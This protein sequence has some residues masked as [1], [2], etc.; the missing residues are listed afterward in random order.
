L[1]HF[2][3]HCA[4]RHLHLSFPV[5]VESCG[6]TSVKF[7][8]QTTVL[9]AASN[10][11]IKIW[12]MR[13]GRAK[14]QFIDPTKEGFITS[15]TR[16]PLQFYHFTTGYSNGTIAL[17]DTRQNAPFMHLQKHSSH[18]WEVHHH[19]AA[20]DNLFTCA[21]D[22]LLY[23]WDLKAIQAGRQ[24]TMFDGRASKDLDQNQRVLIADKLG[25][26]SLHVNPET[27]VLVCASDTHS[28][29]F[30]SVVSDV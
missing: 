4:F 11:T 1:A 30:Q 2:A 29:H 5:R 17:W 12:D 16:H 7:L 25:I 18:V 26:N 22:G 24:E 23:H 8:T 14:Q 27:N 15:V 10:N 20:P 3:A 19:S 9:T 28:L 13:T 6:F 21:E